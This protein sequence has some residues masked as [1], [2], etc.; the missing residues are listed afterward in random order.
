MDWD[1]SYEFLTPELMEAQFTTPAVWVSQHANFPTVTGY[2]IEDVQ[3][4]EGG[5]TARALTLTGFEAKLD[6]VLGLVPFRGRT[7]WALRQTDDGLW[8]VN[9][10]ETEN[11]PLYPNSEGAA[12]TA[13]AWV[14]ARVA[15]EDAADLQEGLVGSSSQAELLCSEDQDETVEIGTVGPLTDSAD[16]E[17]LIAAFGP[18]VFGWARTVRV[19]SAT[20]IIAVLAPIGAEWKVVAVLPAR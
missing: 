10:A 4:D 9:V 3:T 17:P 12:E 5:D 6:P 18:G 8:R 1:A 11:Q 2:E 16:T 19:E 7:T 15:C 14:D 13:R 20:P